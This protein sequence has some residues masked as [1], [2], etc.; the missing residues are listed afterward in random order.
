M[1]EPMNPSETILTQFLGDS[2]LI[3]CLKDD[4][5]VV[6]QQNEHCLKLCGDCTGQACKMGCMELYDNDNSKQWPNWGSRT[7]K[8][9]ELHDDKFDVTI[10]S[11][12]AYI[13]TIMQTMGQKYE[14]ALNYYQTF[15]LGKRELEVIELAIT[16]SSNMEIA[17]HLSISVST[18]RTHLKNIYAKV[19]DAG[20]SME[21]LPVERL[22]QAAG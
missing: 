12:S 6:L 1:I 18:L 15:K 17:E 11:S 20:G 22:Q 21:F 10:I 9:Q 13:L 19:K 5:K 4:N 2:D 7:Y 14:Q 3:L 16:G 8:N